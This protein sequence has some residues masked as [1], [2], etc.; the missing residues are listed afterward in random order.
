VRANDGAGALAGP[1]EDY[2]QPV[3]SCS[4]I[5]MP[6]WDGLRG[7]P[8]AFCNG[9]KKSPIRNT[10]GNNWEM[11]RLWGRNQRGP[12]QGDFRGG[13]VRGSITHLGEAPAAIGAAGSVASPPSTHLPDEGIPRGI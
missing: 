11:T 6:A 12:P 9:L 2:D 8:A 3:L 1:F 4:N 7:W 13:R 5:G 10:S